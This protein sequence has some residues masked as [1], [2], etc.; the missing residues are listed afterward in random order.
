MAEF[1]ENITLDSLIFAIQLFSNRKEEN[2]EKFKEAETFLKKVEK[3][4]LIWIR[5]HEL[6]MLNNLE[7]PV[8]YI[9]NV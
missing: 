9:L 5:S 8:D 7:N 4:K 1:S 2:K 6:L 3:S